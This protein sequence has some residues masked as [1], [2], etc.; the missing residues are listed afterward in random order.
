MKAKI[1]NGLMLALGAAVMFYLFTRTKKGAAF[2]EKTTTRVMSWF[3]PKKAAPFMPLFDAAEKKYGLPPYLL[4][5]VA[6]QESG[7]DPKARNVNTGGSVDS[8]IMQINNVAHPGVNA[9]DP[10]TAIDYAGKYL[11]SL[12][13]QTGTWPLALAAYNWGIGNVKSRP[14]QMPESVKKYANSIAKDVGLV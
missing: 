4:A 2:V 9:S 12:Y 13:L 6:Q 10:A 5:R 7:F 3:P 11:R 1:S 14:A 8:G